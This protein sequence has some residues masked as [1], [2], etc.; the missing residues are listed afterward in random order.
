MGFKN[1]IPDTFIAEPVANLSDLPEDDDPATVRLVEGC[2]PGE[3]C[4]HRKGAG[5][6]VKTCD[7]GWHPNHIGFPILW[8]EY[9]ED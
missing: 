8:K 9:E 2:I 1:K 4:V 7:H 5:M 3:C 6:Y